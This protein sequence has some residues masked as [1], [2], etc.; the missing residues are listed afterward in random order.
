MKFYLLAA[1]AA[2]LQLG[3]P[4]LEATDVALN[5]LVEN[6]LQTK[7][8][9]HCSSSTIKECQEVV[10]GPRGPRGCKGSQGPRGHRGRPG[11]TG[12][13]GANGMNGFTGAQG[14]T[15]AT[16][17]AFEINDFLEATNS[18]EF[19]ATGLVAYIPFT[20]PII[21]PTNGIVGPGLTL[22]ES[23]PLSGNFD[24]ITL[25]AEESDTLYL[26]TF[27]ASVG[28]ESFGIL[29]LELNGTALP[30]TNLGIQDNNQMMSQTNIIRNPAN[31][32]GTLRVLVLADF[33][34]T[35]T[36]PLEGS[37]SAYITVLKLNNNGP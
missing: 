20:S 23:V 1:I 26:V 3:V 16:G 37:S 13:N 14:A 24:T 18:T 6:H 12:P 8:R 11:R 17:P 4:S 36:P 7:R 28:I 25:P 15:G 9:A 35:F 2:S 30:Y 31:T 29:E 33:D 34:L 21:Y 5:N 32:L 10:R 27:G 19:T 22:V